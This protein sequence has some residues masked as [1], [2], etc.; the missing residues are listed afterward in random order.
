MKNVN[1]N[2]SSEENSFEIMHAEIKD[3]Y[4][5]YHYDVLSGVNSGD[6]VKVAFNKTKIIKPSLTKAFGKLD[7]HFAAVDG[8]FKIAG[9]EV[10]DINKFHNHD[11][12]G[13]FSVTGFTVKGEDESQYVILD[14]TK[15]VPY[16]GTHSIKTDKIYIGGMGAYPFSKELAHEIA[17]AK[18]EVEKFKEGNY[19]ELEVVVDPKQPELGAE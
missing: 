17:H 5:A 16:G 19:T 13:K 8:I 18:K 7:V 11:H 9:I 3:D 15:E 6:N 2:E 10:K 4:C 1:Q 12:V 14:G